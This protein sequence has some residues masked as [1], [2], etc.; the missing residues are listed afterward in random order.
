LSLSA[1]GNVLQDKQKADELSALEAKRRKMN[2]KKKRGRTPNTTRGADGFEA[3]EG[4]HKHDTENSAEVRQKEKDTM[5]KQIKANEQIL[6][7]WTKLV[8]KKTLA[9]AAVGAAVSDGRLWPILQPKAFNQSERKLF[10]RICAPNSGVLSK[11]ESEQLQVLAS[12]NVT[13]LKLIAEIETLTTKLTD[14][15][16]QYDEEFSL[17]D[18]SPSVEIMSEDEL[19]DKDEDLLEEITN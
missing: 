19:N 5:E 12:N 11:N 3:A 13:Y 18:A 17:S 14:L 1:V 7:N 2:S 15:K 9:A 6:A 16:K 10:L 4:L 8:E